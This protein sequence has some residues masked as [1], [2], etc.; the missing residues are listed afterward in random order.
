LVPENPDDDPKTCTSWRREDCPEEIVALLQER[1][2]K[3]FGQSKGCNLTSPPF[4]FTMEFCGVL[5]RAEALLD[6]TFTSDKDLFP[7]EDETMTDRE[8]EIRELTKIF[9]E[10]CQYVDEKVKDKISYTLSLEEYKGKV[11]NWDERTST[12]PG[13]NMHLGHLKAYWARH[14]LDKNSEEGKELES[15]RE[16]EKNWSRREKRFLEAI[17]YC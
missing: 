16:E 9:F 5:H 10:A 1:N 17:C 8:R 14:L 11:K 13:T 2:R 3:H 6:G 4:D 15:K 7:D 12:S